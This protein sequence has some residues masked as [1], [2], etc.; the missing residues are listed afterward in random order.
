VVGC[1]R[2]PAN[3]LLLKT[4]LNCCP[5]L[6]NQTRDGEKVA[7]ERAIQSN[8]ASHSAYTIRDPKT[9]IKVNFGRP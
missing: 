5:L 4:L 9:R 2:A 7:V 1:A 3:L 8:T 6:Y